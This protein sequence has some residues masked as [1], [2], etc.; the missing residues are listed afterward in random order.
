[1]FERM[2]EKARQRQEERERQ[3]REEKARLSAL[4][5]KELLVEILMQ[6]KHLED[7]IDEVENTVRLYGN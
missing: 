2:K 7:R 6:L 4:S 1:M 3:I 5:E